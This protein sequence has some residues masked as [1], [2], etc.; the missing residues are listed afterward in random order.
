MSIDIGSVI[1]TLV[2]TLLRGVGAVTGLSSEADRLAKVIEGKSDTPQTP[3]QQIAIGA[4]VN[5]H[6]KDVMDQAL[7][8][9]KV[10]QSE[11]Q[12]EQ[13][14]ETAEIKSEHWFVWGARPFLLY[15]AGVGT[16]ALI[17]A[18]IMQ[19]KFDT[20]AVAELMIPFWGHAGLY[21]VM[22]TREKLA[23][24]KSAST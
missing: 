15:L 1:K 4:L 24:V 8:M 18:T 21:G 19:I 11:L 7:E 10:Q 14:E 3:E 6:A 5:Q 23:A 9:A 2:P 12:G 20:G 13:A 22:R 17:V 16:M